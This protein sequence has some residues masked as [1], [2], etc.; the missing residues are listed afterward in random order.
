MKKFVVGFF[1]QSGAGKTTIIKN[2]PQNI[3]GYEVSPNTGVIRYLFQTNSKK[4]TNPKKL[5]LENEEALNT[6]SG[7][8]RS[9]KIQEIYE[10]YIRSQFQL[11]NDYSTEVFTLVNQTLPVDTILLFDRSPVDFYTLSVCGIDYLKTCFGGVQLNEISTRLL[12]LTQKT[13]EKNSNLMFDMVIL[14]PPWH[15][16]NINSLEDGVRDQ[17]LSEYYTN[18]KWYSKVRNISFTKVKLV[19]L[20]SENLNV[21]E[22]TNL[23]VN[24]LSSSIG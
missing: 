9:G 8:E 19:E 12:D 17:Y 10:R 18:E 4:Y 3:G 1:G 23:V 16:A 21:D 5:L 11:L 15:S 24:I 20:P 6:L 14:T 7:Q 2:L 22:R 13:A